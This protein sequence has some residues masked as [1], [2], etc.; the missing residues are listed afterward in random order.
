MLIKYCKHFRVGVVR[1]VKKKGDNKMKKRSGDEKKQKI[2]SLSVSYLA[3]SLLPPCSNR[4][5]G[6]EFEYARLNLRF[7]QPGQTILSYRIIEATDVSSP[8]VILLFMRQL[9]AYPFGQPYSSKCR[10]I[11]GTLFC[12]LG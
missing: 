2:I 4:R 12:Q 7:L 3:I 8:V 6:T 5:F 1:G 10:S 9:F 11:S